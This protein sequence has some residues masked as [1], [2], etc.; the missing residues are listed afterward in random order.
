MCAH[1][2]LAWHHTILN[3]KTP[4]LRLKIAKGVEIPVAVGSEIVV[5]GQKPSLPAGSRLRVLE[6]HVVA[7]ILEKY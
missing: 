7:F 5:G 2:P 4:Y 6:K 3:V 1:E